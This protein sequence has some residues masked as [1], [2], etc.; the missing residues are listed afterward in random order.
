MA[1]DP[2]TV[3]FILDQIAEAGDV[4][5]RKMF[6]EFGIYCDGKMVAMVC[7]DVLFVKA[8]EGARTF[9]PDLPDGIPY[10]GAKA[11]LLVDAELWD[12]REWLTE[13][14][15]ISARELPAPRPKKP[16]AG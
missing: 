5:A 10:P 13:L 16:R 12:D 2:D 11:C 6:G 8:S 4:A 7:D 9:A 3:A 14:I 1:S 15:R